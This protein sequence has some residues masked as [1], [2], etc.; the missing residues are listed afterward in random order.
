M[1]I[2]TIDI[3]NFLRL[4]RLKLDLTD[5]PVHLFAGH[6]EVGKTS[7]QEA[8]RFCFLGETDRVSKKSDYK[9][10]ITDGGKK[11]EV[12]IVVDRL[13]AGGLDEIA[14]DVATGK[15]TAD[16]YEWPASL[17]YLLDAT[18]YAWVDAKTRRTFMFGLLG[19]TIDRDAVTDKLR[20]REIPPS[21][22]EYILPF[23]RG[24]FDAGNKEAALKTTEARGGWG[25]ITGERHGAVKGEDWKPEI[26]QIDPIELQA[27]ER[28]VKEAELEYEAAVKALGAAG[29]YPLGRNFEC[30][31]CGVSLNLDGPNVREISSKDKQVNPVDDTRPVLEEA[32]AKMKDALDASRAPLEAI[33]RQIRFGKDGEAII[34]QAKEYH[35]QIMSW[36]AMTD[37]LA[38]DGIPGEIISG[39]L[40]PLNKRLMATAMATEWPLVTVTP[41]LEI[42]VDGR[43]FGLQSE[44]S[45]W[46]AQAA[47]A[48]SISHLSEAKLLVLDRIDVLD[49]PNRGKLINWMLGVASD[50]NTIMLIGTL[51]EPP[52]LPAAIKVHWL[53]DGE[54]AKLEAA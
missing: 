23:L 30:P 20:D 22:V 5:A 34:E 37:A 28:A 10:M 39:K 8:I 43:P 48:E 16:D 47:I 49:L 11:G 29:Q 2:K 38:P 12:K 24:G 26:K 54:E 44:S 46:R 14:R 40:A 3:T 19:V 15:G 4:R 27:A 21:M 7:L 13:D 33:Q 50:H 53:V 9:L 35:K 1:K 6:N 42:M 45:Q 31:A 32:V 17:A 41:T 36:K 18:R 51:K 52:R 25:A